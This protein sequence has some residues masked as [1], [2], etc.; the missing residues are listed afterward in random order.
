[1]F[2][3]V[4]EGASSPSGQKA[5]ILLNIL[6][7]KGQ[8]P[9]TSNEPAQMPTAVLPRSLDLRASSR[10]PHQSP[11]PQVQVGSENYN[12]GHLPLVSLEP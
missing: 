3:A 12:E 2:F 6:H 11:C 4:T 7:H 10:Q 9:A 5:G 8:P 1:M